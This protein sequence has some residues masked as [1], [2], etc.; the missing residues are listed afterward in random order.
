MGKFAKEYDGISTQL[1]S[2]LELQKIEVSNQLLNLGRFY[3]VMQKNLETREADMARLA[4]KKSEVISYGK[5]LQ[6]ART[7]SSI[8]PVVLDRLE[9]S[10]E[11]ATDAFEDMKVDIKKSFEATEVGKRGVQKCCRSFLI[12][13]FICAFFDCRGIYLGWERYC[14]SSCRYLPH[15]CNHT[16]TLFTLYIPGPL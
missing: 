14:V 1:C 7:M 9:A 5:Q 6:R 12:F 4:D 3:H 13:F 8:K 2:N 16:H 11:Q 10:I 15:E